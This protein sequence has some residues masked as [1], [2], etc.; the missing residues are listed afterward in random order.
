MPPSWT[1]KE[2]IEDAVVHDEPAAARTSGVALTLELPEAVPPVLAD[3][4]RLMQVMLN[5]ISNAVKF[6]DREGGRIEIA[7]R[8]MRDALRVDVRRQRHRHRHEHQEIIFEKFRQVGDTLTGQ[9]AGHRARAA[10]QPPIMQPLRGHD[11][12]SRA[13]R[14]RRHVLVHAAAVSAPPPAPAP[15]HDTTEAASDPHEDHPHRRG[16]A[17]HRRSR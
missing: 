9:A 16:R 14:P 5:L 11:C 17:Q 3:R 7:L 6:C 13:R 4:D 8:K 10:D 2:V 12:G 1:C 15:A